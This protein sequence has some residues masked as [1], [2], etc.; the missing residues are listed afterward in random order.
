MDES[1]SLLEIHKLLYFMQ[2]AGEP[3]RLKYQKAIYG[4]YA[5]NLRH[6]LSLLNG[7]YISGYD[8]R[9]DSPE[10][11]IEVINGSISEGEVFLENHTGT[12]G[13]FSRVFNL[14][15][16]FESPFGMELLSTV[17]WVAVQEGAVEPKQAADLIYK[18]N[19]RKQMFTK[20]H[21][22]IAWEALTSQ[23]W[24]SEKANQIA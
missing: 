7:H 14:I 21:I 6:V 19:Q 4:P 18:W 20:V 15:N 12:I 23:G 11:T 1:I 3:L 24:I 22:G 13:H 8:D 17:H 16:G 5:Q 10:K 9:V 2:A